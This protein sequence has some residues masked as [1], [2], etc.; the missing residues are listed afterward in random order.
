M[1]PW[2]SGARER[3]LATYF[4][5]LVSIELEALS[6]RLFTGVLG[7]STQRLY[8]LLG[9]VRHEIQDESYQMYSTM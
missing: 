8:V 3:E 4:F 9:R 5:E 7:W 1:S 2:M 6:L